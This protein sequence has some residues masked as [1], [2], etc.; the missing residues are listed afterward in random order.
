MCECFVATRRG[1]TGEEVDAEDHTTTRDGDE[2]IPLS[3]EERLPEEQRL[4]QKGSYKYSILKQI[5]E[6]WCISYSPVLC[7]SVKIVNI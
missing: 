3:T 1:L 5:E 2:T 4:H 7:I 6:S